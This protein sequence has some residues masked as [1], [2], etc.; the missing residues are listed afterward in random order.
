MHS[1]AA[2][3]RSWIERGPG[4]RC[5]GREVGRKQKRLGSRRKTK[6]V[7]RKRVYGPGHPKAGQKHGGGARP[8][9]RRI[10][11]DFKVDGAIPPVGESRFVWMDRVGPKEIRVHTGDVLPG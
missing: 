11:F 10:G 3:R 5:G 7:E 4:E 8:K 9:G 2:A 6:K 1:V